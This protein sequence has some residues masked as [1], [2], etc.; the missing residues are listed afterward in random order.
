[1]LTIAH[2]NGIHQLTIFVATDWIVCLRFVS[3][4]VP[5]VSFVY[6]VDCRLK[7]TN[8][9]SQ[10]VS[11]GLLCTQYSILSQTGFA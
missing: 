4:S 7:H 11:I 9:D 10:D 1:M 8:T 5:V 2:G 3:R 6:D